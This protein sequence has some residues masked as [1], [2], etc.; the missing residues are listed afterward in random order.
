MTDAWTPIDDPTVLQQLNQSPNWAPVDPRTAKFLDQTGGWS[1]TNSPFGGFLRGL[2]DPIDQG[3]AL[4]THGLAA[5]APESLQPWA[6]GQIQNVEGVNRG[7]ERDYNENWR[8]GTPPGF[9]IGRF[10][11]NI[12]STAPLAYAMPG[13]AAASLPARMLSG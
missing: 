13:A 6:Q 12:A 11:G 2:R 3:A 9:D 5:I 10:A 4:L 1:L 7:A 8:G